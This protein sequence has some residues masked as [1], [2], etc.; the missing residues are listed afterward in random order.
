MEYRTIRGKASAE[1][2][3]KRSRFIAEITPAGDEQTALRFIEEIRAA[4]R[5]ARHHVFAYVI[6]DRLFR[7]SDDGEPQGPGGLPAYEVLAREE[8]RFTAV[9][10]TRYF[11]GT[12]L[13]A[14]GLVRAYSRACRLAVEAAGIVVMRRCLRLS[15]SCP[16]SLYDRVQHAVAV[17]GG[18]IEHADY[19]GQVTVTVL[20]PE[21]GAAAL[22]Q[23]V[24]N[25]TAGGSRPR[26]LEEIYAAAGGRPPEE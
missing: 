14:P 26:I 19:G 2:V 11:G 10:I 4:S 8:L 1:F 21:T 9:V 3:E 7:Y 20:I 24:V 5:D 23:A 17:C 12:L 6:Q 13:G 25:L 16:Y 15:F 18:R 22:E